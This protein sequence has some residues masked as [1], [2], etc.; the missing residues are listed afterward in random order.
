MASTRRLVLLG[1]IAA[2]SLF[3]VPAVANAI[4]YCVPND[5]ID[6]SCTTGQGKATVQ[7]ALDAAEANT[8]NDTVRI[9][10]GTFTSAGIS[11]FR[12]EA[13]DG[14]VSIVGAG[15]G[16]TTLTHQ[17]D[18][19]GAFHINNVLFLDGTGVGSSISNLTAAIP[20]PTD[21]TFNSQHRAIEARAVLIDHVT[22]TEPGGTALNSYGFWIDPGSTTI[23]NST[24]DFPAPGGQ[25]GVITSTGGDVQIQDSDITA[26][27][28]AVLRAAGLTNT[29]TRT[30]INVVAANAG[31]DVQDGTLNLESSL[32][33]LGSMSAIG[34][35][36][37]GASGDSTATM[38]LDHAT[39]VG[40]DPGA[41]GVRVQANDVAGADT[42]SATLTNSVLSLPGTAIRRSADQSDTANVTTNYSN[43]DPTGNVS[44]NGTSGSGAL[45][46]THQTN[47]PPGFVGSGDFHLAS[48]SALIDAGDP[49]GPPF[50]ATDIDGD[51]REILG[52]DGCAPRRDIG[53]DEFVP[54]T[55]PTLLDCDPPNTSFLSGPSG[56][57][58]D[59]TPTFTFDS[60][61]QPATFQ[62]SVD[63]NPATACS[64][65]F[66][67]TQLSDG[68][69]T[70]AVQAI[71]GSMNVDPTPATR[72]FT[73][74]TTA[75]ETTIGSH[76]KPKT[77][78]R[79]ATFTFSSSEA[80]STFLCSFDG[81]P[82]AACSS[83]F[84]TPKLARGKHRFD[85]IATDPLG[86]G[87]ASAATFFW[88]VKKRR[89]R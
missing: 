42:H 25:D 70:F 76:P 77:K 18:P 23:A 63:G 32:I 85:V 56:A 34:A 29:I 57:T 88:K 11:G 43:Y 71:D 4:V 79:K 59:T 67:A 10:T 20:L 39:I 87:D 8:G 17:P 46:Q 38:N 1:G 5:T 35:R 55:P 26:R 2:L 69:H 80:G 68:P 66:T 14:H 44:S 12:Y 84:T 28:G 22:V 75:P 62:C 16:L 3:A 13:G 31:V 27:A 48:S 74:D 33:D 51:D 72:S 7:D 82:Y 21:N 37:T 73:V 45:T 65:P 52:K 6:A 40:T 24:V 58:T 64:S 81:Q 9:G 36:A 41:E 19:G 49:G 86:H 83:P 54:L 89:H 60:S 61:E 53:A 50:G 78:S 30:T 15:E 47:L